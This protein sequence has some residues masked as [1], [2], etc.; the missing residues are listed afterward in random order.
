MPYFLSNLVFTPW[1]LVSVINGNRYLHETV[2]YVKGKP[3]FSPRS[4]MTRNAPCVGFSA[5]P[6]SKSFPHS[7]APIHQGSLRF[8]I[9]IIFTAALWPWDRLRFWQKWLS[10]GVKAAGATADNLTTFMCRQSINSGSFNL[11]E[12]ERPV[13]G[14]IGITFTLFSRPAALRT[15]EAEYG[16]T[17][18][19]PPLHPSVCY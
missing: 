10:V 8:V 15:C 9:L 19:H 3:R 7:P 4:A 6:N 1:C 2:R 18:F 12:P 5:T 16:G 17:I 14:C 13:H 11:L